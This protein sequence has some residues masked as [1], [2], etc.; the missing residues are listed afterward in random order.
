MHTRITTVSFKR[1]IRR[2]LSVRE[3]ITVIK[4]CMRKITAVYSNIHL[5]N[6]ETKRHGLLLLVSSRK[7]TT[8]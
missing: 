3:A 1:L 7:Y 6:K 2:A 8:S 5:I 4:T